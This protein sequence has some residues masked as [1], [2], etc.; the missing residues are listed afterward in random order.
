MGMC[1]RSPRQSEA[2]AGR[3]EIDTDKKPNK[4]IVCLPEAPGSVKGCLGQEGGQIRK[5]RECHKIAWKNGG[6]QQNNENPGD[7]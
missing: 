7:W 1:V 5:G 6:G 4:K 2:P 3:E